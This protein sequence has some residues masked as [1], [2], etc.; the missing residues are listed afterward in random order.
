MIRTEPRSGTRK[1]IKKIVEV[2]QSEVVHDSE[3]T[4]NRGKT[5]LNS[6]NK[7]TVAGST[8][9]NTINLAGDSKDKKN[10][11]KV[12][13]PVSDTVERYTGYLGGAI[14]LSNNNLTSLADFMDVTKKIMETP[15]SVKWLDLSFNNF[16]SL[17]SIQA[18]PLDLEVLYLHG[19]DIGEIKEI[20]KLSKFKNLRS[21][22]L[23]G[24]PMDEVR[25]YRY[26]ILALIPSLKS[27]DFAAV[28]RQ[29][30]DTAVTFSSLFLKRT[31][32]KT[33]ET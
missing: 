16:Y 3:L 20:A 29:D 33:A 24:N 1:K 19:N 17:D 5:K 2:K 8:L 13:T 23:H 32:K 28:T 7:S 27:L 10:D 14:K 26:H 9:T 22:T 6:T 30:A 15:E 12:V 25:N 31:K 18:L 11:D 21:L 4:I